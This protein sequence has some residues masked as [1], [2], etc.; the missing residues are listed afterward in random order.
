MNC[1]CTKLWQNLDEWK[2]KSKSTAEKL[3][4]GKMFHDF[5]NGIRDELTDVDGALSR[6]TNTIVNK[7]VD[8]TNEQN[9]RQ[10]SPVE[11][12]QQY[13]QVAQQIVSRMN[14]F[15]TSHSHRPEVL[16]YATFRLVHTFLHKIK[17]RLNSENFKEITI[18]VD[19]DVLDKVNILMPALKLKELAIGFACSRCCLLKPT[20]PVIS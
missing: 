5:G 7:A 4:R 18:D 19:I 14:E 12:D 3:D 11:I 8:N 13:M 17:T 2:G 15:N 9:P 10:R 6:I 20:I 16:R 1:S